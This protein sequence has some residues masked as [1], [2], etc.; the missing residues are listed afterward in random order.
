MGGTMSGLMGEPAKRRKRRKTT[1][2]AST[3]SVGTKRKTTK[4]KST[5]S[6]ST[7]KKALKYMHG[8]GKKLH[9]HKTKKALNKCK[10]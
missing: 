8:S 1:K 6:K 2:R 3:K 9:G 10:K 7:G 5:K 4:R